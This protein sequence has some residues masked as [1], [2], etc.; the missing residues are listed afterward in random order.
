[1]KTSVFLVPEGDADE[2]CS[3]EEVSRENGRLLLRFLV[4]ELLIVLVWRP[5][6]KLSSDFELWKVGDVD[7]ARS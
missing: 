7:P 5:F 6:V 1:M 3:A 4:S 2:D